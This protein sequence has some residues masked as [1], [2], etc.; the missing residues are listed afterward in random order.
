MGKF[1][2]QHLIKVLGTVAGKDVLR[3]AV[4]IISQQIISAAKYY[5]GV[6]DG[7]YF[8]STDFPESVVTAKKAYITLNTIMG[9]ETAEADRFR[10]GK[11]Q[12][13]ELFTPLGVEKMLTLF[14]HLY[15]FGSGSQE[16]I[17]CETVRACRQ[18]EV[19][20]GVSF[21]GPLTSTTK[22]SVDEIMQLGYGNKNGLA[23]CFY[24]FHEGACLF[25]M[26][27]LG[28]DYLKPEEREVLLLM[29]NKL[30]ACCQ[31]Y[32]NRYLGKDGQPALIYTIDVYQP[33]FEPIAETQQELESVV[34]CPQ[35]IEKVR[36]FYVAL[37]GEGDFPEIPDYYKEWKSCFQKLVFLEIQKLV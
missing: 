13:P 34:Y 11:K 18:T 4:P 19:S 23:I 26:E 7:K 20:E 6:P 21:V 27:L 33:E 9:G 1:D 5:M 14:T 29:K 36:D 10:E 22:L 28:N 8:S 37:N 24:N 17:D 12:I 16:A 25:D 3:K 32:D 31:G 30:V 35:T 2:K 15:C